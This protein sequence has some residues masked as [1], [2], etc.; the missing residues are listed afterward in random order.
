MPW[1]QI[2]LNSTADHAEAL[3]DILT[4]AGAVSVT[5]QDS[6]DNPVLNPYRVKLVFGEIRMLLVY[7][8]QK[9]IWSRLLIN[10][11]VTL[12]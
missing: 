10:L 7:L 2:R 12:Y 4:E 8:M 9:A 6:Y 1:I 5:F 3:S 11:Q